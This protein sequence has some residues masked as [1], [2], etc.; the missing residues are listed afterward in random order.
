MNST[1]SIIRQVPDFRLDMNSRS[2]KLN[3]AQVKGLIVMNTCNMTKRK[4]TIR[5]FN[6][7]KKLSLSKNVGW[8]DD[9]YE[10]GR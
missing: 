5:T 6:M 3:V 10:K 9:D 2:R 7:L 1:L 4:V 8:K